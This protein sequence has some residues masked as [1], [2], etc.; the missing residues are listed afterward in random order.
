[1]HP[2]TQAHPDGPGSDP[3]LHPVPPNGTPGPPIPGSHL[4]PSSLSTDPP[5]G[6]VPPSPAQRPDGLVVPPRAL[7]ADPLLLTPHVPA[8]PPRTPP[9][10]PP[11]PDSPALPTTVDEP[12]PPRPPVKIS[13]LVPPVSRFARKRD[14]PPPEQATR[15]PAARPDTARTPRTKT[16]DP[17]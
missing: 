13:P 7:A 1:M 10:P 14:A 15:K 16:E 12:P 4:L 11:A 8:A 5:P 6:A 17:R 9:P 3:R 2:A